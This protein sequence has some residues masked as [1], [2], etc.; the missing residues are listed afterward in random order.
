MRQYGATICVRRNPTKASCT[1][2]SVQIEAQ[3]IDKFRD[4]EFA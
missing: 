2:I 4:A 3:F 1:A